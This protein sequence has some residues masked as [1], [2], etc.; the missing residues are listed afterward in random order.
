MTA[1]FSYPLIP[2][3]GEDAWHPGIE[4]R[5][6]LRLMR[7]C[8]IFLPEHAERSYDQ[9]AALRDLCGLPVEDLAVLNAERLA[10]HEVLVQV[11]ANWVVPDGP[12]VADLGISFRGMVDVLLDGYVTPELPRLEALVSALRQRVEQILEAEWASLHHQAQASKTPEPEKPSS[13]FGK[14]SK[15]LG[16]N[17]NPDHHLAAPSSQATRA[18]LDEVSDRDVAVLAELEAHT[19]QEAEPEVMTARSA[20]RRVMFGIHNRHGRLWG[21]QAVVISIAREL[22]IRTLAPR[23]LGPE[24][25]TLL[26]IGGAKEGYHRLPIQT[27]PM[28]MN[29]KGASGSGK[30]TMRPLQQGLADRL[31]V[32]WEDFALISPDIWRKRLLDYASMGKDH[33]YAGFCTG[34]EVQI[35]DLKLDRFMAKKAESGE[36]THLLIDRF[37]FDS[38]A[39]DSSEAGT[40][41]LTRFGQDV[42]MFFMITPPEAIVARAWKRGLDVGRF[43][44]VEDILGHNVE[45][46]GGIPLLFFRWANRKDK[47]VHYEFLDNTQPL[48]TPPKTVAFGLNGCMVILDAQG[49]VN[50]ERFRRINVHAGSPEELYPNP[51]AV[52]LDKCMG[53]LTQCAREIAQIYF[54]DQANGMTWLQWKDGV[55]TLPSVELAEQ[56]LSIDVNRAV[57]YAMFGDAQIQAALESAHQRSHHAPSES[58]QVHVRSL[59]NESDI[60]SLGLWDWEN[61]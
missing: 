45:A 21:D 23:I 24:I 60:Q 8:T 10:L 19:K 1:Q 9:A 2:L 54:A 50:I 40:S 41:L 53:L 3:P 38:F 33:K 46:Y 34:H 20:L 16:F 39:P 30:S 25:K 49:L 22:A 29:T 32:R 55:L 61:Q 15:L 42:Y 57:V 52:S 35:I 58:Q 44:A 48:G 4:N 47:H 43:K 11:T 13:L 18:M 26:D 5:V 12:K 6:P 31:G 28:V 7:R 17:S 36:M 37:R 14:I 59:L 56:Q 51:D 27:R